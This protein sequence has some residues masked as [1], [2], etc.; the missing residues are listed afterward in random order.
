LITDMNH[1]YMHFILQKEYG[2]RVSAMWDNV[3]EYGE[4]DGVY[5]NFSMS[6]AK[7]AGPKKEGSHR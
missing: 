3:S 4:L 7:S 5:E 2:V 6:S 1:E